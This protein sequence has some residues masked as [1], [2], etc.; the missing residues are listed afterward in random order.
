MKT[1]ATLASILALSL[2]GQA[3]D[4]E[5]SQKKT[6]SLT[7]D[8]DGVKPDGKVRKEIRVGPPDGPKGMLTI[9]AGTLE[10]NEPKT[11]LGVV[12]GE[13]S[14]ALVSQL[15]LDPGTGL[16]V[17]HVTPESPAAKAGLQKHD[18][19]V[20]LGDQVLIT[21]KQFQTLIANHKA[22]DAVEIALL[23]KG[24]PQTITA[25][26]ATHQPGDGLADHEA[27]INLYGAKMDFDRLIKEAHD[28]AGSII[29]NK[30]TVFVGPDGKPVT[31]DSDEIREKTLEMLRQSG[32]NRET[33]D[34]V[35]RALSEAQEQ[36]RKAAEQAKGAFGDSFHDPQTKD[37][38]EEARRAAKEVAAAVE[39]AKDL[40]NRLEKKDTAERPK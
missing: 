12:L 11:W 24:Q 37:A 28:T 34:Q 1:I 39:R 15:P 31:I 22:G 29:L 36:I 21:P 26:L 33:L 9:D 10:K 3:Q 23:R 35:K 20:R 18:V 17:E 16:L 14:E 30:K 6:L 40:Q 2:V 4:L 13:V 25:T 5:K 8:S 27:T 7:L 19:L 32:L 38:V